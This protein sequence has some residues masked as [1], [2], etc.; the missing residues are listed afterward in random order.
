MIFGD[1]HG[2]LDEF[3]VLRLLGFNFVERECVSAIGT[4]GEFEFDDF[5]DPFGSDG[6]AEVLFMPGLGPMLRF[7]LLSLSFVFGGLTMSDEGGLEL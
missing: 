7:V 2:F 6:F 5:V 4:V 3:D 1:D